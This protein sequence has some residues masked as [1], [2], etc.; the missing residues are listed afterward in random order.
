MPVHNLRLKLIDADLELK[1][2]T[3]V[4]YEDLVDK[5]N[6]E[7]EK[8]ENIYMENMWDDNLANEFMTQQFY[9]DENYTMKE[10]YHIANYY[11][12]SKR[13]KKKA[14]LIDDIIAFE[15]DNE[16]CEVVETRKR[17]WFY[18]NEIKNDNYLSKFIILE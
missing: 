8:K 11:D 15:L 5:V 7:S 18:L 12:I 13:K 1:D 4:T 14:E 16:N 2:K 9:Y 10:L 3:D 6:I 17:L